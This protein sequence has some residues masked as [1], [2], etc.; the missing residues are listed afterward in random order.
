MGFV[1]DEDDT[2][3]FLQVLRGFLVSM[4]LSVFQTQPLFYFQQYIFVKIN[5]AIKN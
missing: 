3:V 4:V 5:S 1:V 2:E